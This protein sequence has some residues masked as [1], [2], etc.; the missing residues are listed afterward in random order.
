MPIPCSV[1]QIY[2]AII[3]HKILYNILGLGQFS[4]TQFSCNIIS[5]NG[6]SQIKPTGTSKLVQ[7]CTLKTRLL[8]LGR[9]Q[10]N[11]L[12][13]TQGAHTPWGCKVTF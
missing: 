11:Q 9:L 2:E 6:A 8:V 7:Y 10:V 5:C 3:N 4:T 12:F 13:P 1:L